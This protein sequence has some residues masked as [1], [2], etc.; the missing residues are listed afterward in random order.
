MIAL[1]REVAYLA[2]QW[3]DSRCFAVRSMSSSR[4]CGAPRALPV[5]VA[6]VGGDTLARRC[7]AVTQLTRL[8]ASRPDRDTMEWTSSALRAAVSCR[9]IAIC[10]GVA[11]APPPRDLPPRPEKPPLGAPRPEKPSPLPPGPLPLIPLPRLSELLLLLLC[12]LCLPELHA[13][14]P[15]EAPRPRA[16]S[17]PP[18]RPLMGPLIALGLTKSSRLQ[19]SECDLPRLYYDDSCRL[20]CGGRQSCSSYIV[21]RRIAAVATPYRTIAYVYCNSWGT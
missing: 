15:P 8:K 6:A 21:R 17:L 3:P 11:I 7:R 20:R 14:R 12:P 10:S 18:P 13:P 1:G 19:L 16:L 5:P 4:E 2:S 9:L